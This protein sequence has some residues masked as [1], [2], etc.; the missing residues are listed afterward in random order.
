LP[1]SMAFQVAGGVDIDLAPGKIVQEVQKYRRDGLAHLMPRTHKDTPFTLPQWGKP[2]DVVERRELPQLKAK[3]LRFGNNVRLNFV[4]SRQEPGLARAVVR[5][6]SGLVNMPGNKPALK[7]F[8]LN[9]L[10]ASGA[11]HIR[12]EQLNAL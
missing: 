10:L 2:T 11:A 5:V 7:E 4:S 3:L 1:S 6:C 8:G 9:T 12:P